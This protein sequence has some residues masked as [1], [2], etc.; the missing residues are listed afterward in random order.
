M[1][2]FKRNIIWVSI[3]LLFACTISA[4]S[5]HLG[6]WLIYAGNNK[7]NNKW[8]I[9]YDVQLRQY[10]ILTQRNQLLLRGGIG[11]NLKENNHNLLLGLAYIE[12]S[13]YDKE[14]QIQSVFSETRIYQQYI[15]KQNRNNYFFAHRF[16]LEERF[17]SN[18]FGLRS[19]YH[20]SVQKPLNNKGLIK[21]HNYFSAYNELFIDIKS[22]KFDRNRLYAGLGYGITDGIRI[23]T[24]YMIQSQKNI[25]RGQLQFILI[26]NLSF[27]KTNRK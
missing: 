21:N 4:Q 23:E 22:G 26:N 1:H 10:Q 24:G 3:L 17:F 7:I 9:Q 13:T 2:L 5:N 16:R 11:Y 25:T 14:D 27:I 19:R 6:S 12:T 20:L 15:F 18:D 8:N